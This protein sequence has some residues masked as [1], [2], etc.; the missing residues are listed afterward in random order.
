MAK[1]R[2][3]EIRLLDAA[4]AMQALVRDPDDTAQV[5]R[6]IEALAGNNLFRN[7]ARLRRVAW[8]RSMLEEQPNLLSHLL[9]S[10]RLRSLPENSLGRAYLRFLESEGISAEGL[11]QASIDGQD[12]E[13]EP[14][15]AE[16]EFFRGRMRDSHDLWH[17]ITGY[18]GDI[19]GEAALLAFTF[20]QMRNPGIGFIV[21]VAFFRDSRAGFKRE[22]MR[23]FRNGLRATWLP[24]ARWEQLLALPI[25]EVRRQLGVRPTPGYTPYRSQQYKE[26]KGY[27]A[28][29][30]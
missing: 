1:R 13:L 16:A 14:L 22:I 12:Q 4:R 3:G 24:A 18:Q 10:E 2:H 6:I 11:Y 30:A 15:P 21:T 26:A 8:G 7:V 19:V 25:D 20:A 23:G 17:T 28:Q 29:A 5:F 9:D 27:V